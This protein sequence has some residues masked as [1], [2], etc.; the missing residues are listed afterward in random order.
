GY[1]R[2]RFVGASLYNGRR[3]LPMLASRG[4]PYQCTFCTAPAM[5]APLWQARPVKD[6][7][8]EMAFHKERYG[9]TDF[10]I[11]DLTM[12]V[13]RSWVEEFSAELI[14]RDLGVTW[15]LHSGTRL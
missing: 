5:W 8:D 11:H 15:Q 6:V 3:S 10:S 1:Q 9:V 12:V 7:V 4:C 14:Q 2:K 13:K